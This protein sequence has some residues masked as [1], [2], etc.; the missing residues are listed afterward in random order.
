MEKTL[1]QPQKPHFLLFSNPLHKNSHDYIKMY[2][3][4]FECLMF[5]FQKH[6]EMFW[7]KYY[8]RKNKT[9]EYAI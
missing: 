5:Q 8:F 4:L 1:K 9:K 3:V 6:K 7:M 2:I